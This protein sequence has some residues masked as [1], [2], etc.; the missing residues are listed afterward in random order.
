MER[1]KAIG[2]AL[3]RSRSSDAA[4]RIYSIPDL[5]KLVDDDRVW[6]RLGELLDD[7]IVTTEIDAARVLSASRELDGI[8]VVLEELG[9][10]ADDPDAD[11]MAY[12]LYELEA[13]GEGPFMASLA[14]SGNSMTDN[15]LSA[16]EDLKVLLGPQFT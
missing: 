6:V 7:E 15:Q 1:E 8:L 14:A 11:Y 4:T 2:D 9:R 3:S 13:S 16:L 10:R 12:V 5:A